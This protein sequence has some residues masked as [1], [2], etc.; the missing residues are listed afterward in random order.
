MVETGKRIVVSPYAEQ[1]LDTVTCG[2]YACYVLQRLMD[3]TSSWTQIIRRELQ[4]ARYAA[5]DRLVVSGYKHEALGYFPP[6]C[7]RHA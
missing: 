7:S 5:N 3:S 4:P 2:F 6:F 1:Q